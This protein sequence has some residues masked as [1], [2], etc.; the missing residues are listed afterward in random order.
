[1]VILAAVALPT[2]RVDAGDLWEVLVTNTDG[3]G[4]PGVLTT[5]PGPPDVRDNHTHPGG[6]TPTPPAEA[7]PAVTPTRRPREQQDSRTTHA[8]VRNAK[9]DT[10]SR[11][12]SESG[13]P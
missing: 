4:V 8:S 7:R 2:P 10:R 12:A 13:A 1:M 9:S 6:G 5:G 3:S 11:P